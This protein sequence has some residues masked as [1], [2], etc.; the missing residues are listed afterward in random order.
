M[1]DVGQRERPVQDR[2]VELF[3]DQLG[4]RYSATGSTAKATATSRRR[5]CGR[6]W[7]SAARVIRSYV[8]REELGKYDVST[9]EIFEIVKNQR[10]Y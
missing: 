9:D 1:S 6:G 2:V 4:Y 10:E 5:T 8:V 7:E 3:R